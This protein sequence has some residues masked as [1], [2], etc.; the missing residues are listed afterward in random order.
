MEPMRPVDIGR[1]SPPKRWWQRWGW[2]ICGAVTFLL[3]LLLAAAG[4]T[5]LWVVVLISVA[6]GACWQAVETVA[7]RRLRATSAAGAPR[8]TRHSGTSPEES[9]PD[10]SI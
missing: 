10:S 2:R 1:Q 9:S 7:T 4:E 8:S 5:S 6:V 3:G